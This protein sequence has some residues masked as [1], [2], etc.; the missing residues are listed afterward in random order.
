MV[1]IYIDHSEKEIKKSS[2]EAISYGAAIAKQLGCSAEALLLGTV[3]DDL[4]TLG[5]LGAS[6]VHQLNN[7]SLNNFDAKVHASLIATTAS[8]LNAEVIVFAHNI[9]GKAIAP[10]VAVKLDAGIVTGACSLPSLQNG[11]EVTKTV[12]SGK[13]FA[14]IKI[15]T[16]KKVIAINQNSFGIQNYDSS[17][18]I[19]EMNLPIPT[20]SV[21]VTNVNKII[22][23]IPLTEANLV[24]SGGRGLKGPENWGILLDLAKA[25]G[26]ATA[27]SRPVSDSDWRPHH[28]HVGQTGIQIAPNLYI[29]IGIS[30]AIQHLA[31]VNRSKTI[32]VINKDPEAPFFKAADYGVVGDAF[33]VVPAFTAAI[34]KMKHNE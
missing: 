4:T 6:K 30:G 1:L 10:S 16:P 24:V 26:A 11:F 20:A 9:N 5:K 34:L 12:F 2:H 32:V 8:N 27:C 31:G 15:E 17:A 23:E 28:E 13:A 19:E 18:T 3:N 7:E 33:E 14:S 25:L 29:A 22:G 21:K